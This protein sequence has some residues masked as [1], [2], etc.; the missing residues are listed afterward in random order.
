[1]RHSIHEDKAKA[2][3]I[4]EFDKPS[5]LVEY[6]RHLASQYNECDQQQMHK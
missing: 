2:N 6:L 1:M 3:N 5:A 4:N